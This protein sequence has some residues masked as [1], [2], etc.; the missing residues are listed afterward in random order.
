MKLYKQSR[1]FERNMTFQCGT[2][3]HYD[4]SFEFNLGLGIEFGFGSVLELGLRSVF[5]IGPR[6]STLNRSR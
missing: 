6:L 4:G 1:K 3:R 5:M 2:T